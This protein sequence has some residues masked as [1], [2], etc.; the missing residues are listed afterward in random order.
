VPE[1]VRIDNAFLPARPT[2]TIN[3]K[4]NLPQI[5]QTASYSAAIPNSE[6]LKV[7][8][9][10]VDPTTAGAGVVSAADSD[11]FV[12]QSISGGAI[13]V[14]STSGAPVNVQIRW[15]KT[16]N[17]PAD[18]WNAFY[19]TDS[20][21][22]GVANKWVNIGQNYV[23][24]AD[25]SLTPAVDTAT[26]AGVTVNGVSI[27]ALTLRHQA[28][29]VTQFD[30]SNGSAQVTELSQNGFAAGKFVS[31]AI[32]NNGR[33]VAKYSNGESVERAQIV[34]ANFNAP[35]QLKKLDGGTYSTTS[36]SGEAI[37]DNGGDGI[38]GASLEASNTDIS[39]EFTRLI[40]TQQAYAA[41]T[42]IVTTSDEMLQE[43]LNM[44]R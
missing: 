39:E 17:T 23:F 20:A 38:Q 14:F 7:V 36:E 16:A 44:V 34:T 11:T 5:P 30:D 3:Y 1:V 32:N 41:G 35:N 37:F 2:T 31:V 24:A 33:I 22:V 9:Y 21:A 12:N 28:M 19:L 4:L 15:A 43:A 10:T 26:I 42:R 25:G 6:L 13:T 18:S 27:G 8:D 29:G 40:V